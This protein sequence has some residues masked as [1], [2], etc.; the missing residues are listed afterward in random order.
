V[1]DEI[2]GEATEVFLVPASPELTEDLVKNE[3]RQR[4]PLF[5][6]PKWVEFRASLPKNQSGKILKSVLSEQESSRPES[7]G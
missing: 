6:Q 4:L 5:K 7:R 3:L 2:L 1:D